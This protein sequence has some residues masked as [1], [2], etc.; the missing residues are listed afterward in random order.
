MGL[1]GGDGPG[2]G[3]PQAAP[4]R[5][6]GG[7]LADGLQLAG[8]GVLLQLHKVCLHHG[9]YVS[10]LTLD[11]LAVKG[12]NHWLLQAGCVRYPATIQREI[13]TW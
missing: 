2:A 12:G 5:P 8:G 13:H 11:I 6:V 7:L 3:G 1:P 10:P 9:V 4:G